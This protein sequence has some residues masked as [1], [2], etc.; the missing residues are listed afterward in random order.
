MVDVLAQS[1]TIDGNIGI[2]DPKGM[3]GFTLEVETFLSLALATHLKTLQNVLEA[4]GCNEYQILPCIIAQGEMLL[5]ADEK[6]NGTLLLDIGQ[7]ATSAVMYY[8]GA[9]VEAWEIPLGQDR[10]AQAVA[11]LLQND[12]ETAQEVLKKTL[13]ETEEKVN[14]VCIGSLSN[15]GE[16]LSYY[17]NPNDKINM[18]SIMAGE[19]EKQHPEHNI[20]CDPEAAQVVLS[21]GLP[22]F[23]GT[24]HQARM[25]SFPEEDLKKYFPNPDNGFFFQEDFWNRAEQTVPHPLSQLLC[26]KIYGRKCGCNLF[27]DRTV[28]HG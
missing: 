14:I 27:A 25:I 17:P 20:M 22:V 8:K 28:W 24:F 23:L 26:I 3:V 5:T 1:Y 9:L 7:T 10:L 19:I 4:C 18:I 16:L 2:T 15:I 13:D 11:D 6:Q 21:Y 12:L